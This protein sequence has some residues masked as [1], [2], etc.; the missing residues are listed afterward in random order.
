MSFVSGGK[1]KYIEKEKEETPKKKTSSK[2]DNRNNVIDALDFMLANN[3]IDTKQ[4]NELMVKS[5][6]YIE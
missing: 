5:L 3:I 4:Y 2:S 6:P 1:G